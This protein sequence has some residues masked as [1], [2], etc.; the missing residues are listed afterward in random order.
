MSDDQERLRL[1][2]RAPEVGL[3]FGIERVLNL[4]EQILK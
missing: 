1:A 4:W 3:R 2:A